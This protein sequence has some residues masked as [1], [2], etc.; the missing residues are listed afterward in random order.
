M[1][2]PS[3]IGAAAEREVAYALESA[4]WTV[5]LPVF[6]AHSRVDLVGGVRFAADYEIVCQ[7]DRGPSPD[8]AEL[9]DV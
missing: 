3:Q 1:P 9:T 6:V 7:A 2:T 4:G 5:F 8:A